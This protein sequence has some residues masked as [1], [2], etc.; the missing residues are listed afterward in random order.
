MLRSPG[1]RTPSLVSV[2]VLARWGWGPKQVIL[3]PSELQF[4]PAKWEP[5]SCG[6]WETVSIEHPEQGLA[7]HSHDWV[8]IIIWGTQYWQCY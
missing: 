6:G 8:T 2:P 3:M 5:F 7:G 4:V 1:G